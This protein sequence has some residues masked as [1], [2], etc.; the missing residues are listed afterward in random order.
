ML[1][2]KI[3]LL[4]LIILIGI[5]GIS[6]T[7]ILIS[8][9]LHTVDV[10][11]SDVIRPNDSLGLKFENASYGFHFGL[12]FRFNF[13]N[14]YIQ[15]ELIFNSNKA[16]FIFT[17]ATVKSSYDSLRTEKYQYLDVPLILGLKFSIIRLFAGPVAHF[18]INN[19]SELTDIQGYKD[20]FDAATFGYQVG[21]GF[22][23]KFLSLDIRHEG[24]FSNY[25]DHINFF[26]EKLDF[27]N[28][29]TRLIGSLGIKF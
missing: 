21:L 9:G 17:D 18:F 12:G 29:P 7:D 26:G 4:L 11:S 6:Q 25:G 1:V 27:D 14:F 19:T 20:K 5:R 16:N 22:D 10:S 13:R 24:N 8:G 23:Y 28:K 3:N 15:P 2:R